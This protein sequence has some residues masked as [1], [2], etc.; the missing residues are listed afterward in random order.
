MVMPQINGGETPRI[1]LLQ[2]P[3][4]PTPPATLIPNTYTYPAA[5]NLYRKPQIPPQ[6]ENTSQAS[7]SFRRE[8]AGQHED[9]E[10]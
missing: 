4:L 3:A 7:P 1:P 5:L 8:G 10:I 2:H 9:A 6:E